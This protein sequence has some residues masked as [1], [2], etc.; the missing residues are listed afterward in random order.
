M[1]E[2]ADPA[3]VIQEVTQALGGIEDRLLQ[4]IRNGSQGTASLGDVIDQLVG[5]IVDLRQPYRRVHEA[6]DRRD[7]MLVTTEHLEALRARIL[8]L[9]R[10]SRLEHLFFLKLRLERS[11]RD[12]L[13]RQVIESFEEITTLD[14]HERTMR[15]VGEEVLAADLLGNLDLTEPHSTNP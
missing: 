3:V 6:L 12:S 8:R 9:Y 2:V 4:G 15:A 5:V 10:K 13:Y 1:S 14:E 7:L 11:L